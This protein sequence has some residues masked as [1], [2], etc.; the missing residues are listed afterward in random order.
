MQKEVSWLLKEK[1]NNSPNKNFNKDISRLNRGEPVDYII[2]FTEFLGCKIDLS[3]KP[4]IPR[5]ETEFWVQKAIEDIA[6]LADKNG[7]VRCLDLFSGSGCIGVSILKSDHRLLCDM[8]D[9]RLDC[10]K[11]AKINCALNAVNSKRCR[12]IKTNVFSNIKAKYDY[13]LANPPYIAKNRAGSIQKS[14]LHFEPKSALFGG[15]DGL[16]YIKNFISGA[17]KHLNPGGKIY[18]EFSPEQKSIIENIIRKSAY[19]SYRF[20]KDQYGKWRWVVIE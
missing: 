4:L 13:I 1:Y 10:L 11:Q 6:R 18:M 14:V 16:L 3:K 2:G 7:L 19:Q 12:L 20:Y 15:I 9:N 5:P 17:G 8:A